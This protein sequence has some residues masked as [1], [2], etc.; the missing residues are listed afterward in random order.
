MP[1]Y[2]VNGEEST[3]LA[4]DGKVSVAYENGD[5]FEGSYDVSKKKSGSGVYTWSAGEDAPEDAPRQR[6]SGE[7]A[8]G[9]RNGFGTMEYTSGDSY[10][11]SWASNKRN[12]EGVYYYANGDIYSGTWESDAKN[13]PGTMNFA[14]GSQLVGEWYNGEISQGQWTWADGTVYR[15]GFVNGKPAGQG[16][17]SFPSG[18]TQGGKFSGGNWSGGSIGGPRSFSESLTVD[19][20]LAI[21]GNENTMVVEDVDVNSTFAE[22]RARIRLM[23]T[24]SSWPSWSAIKWDAGPSDDSTIA[25]HGLHKPDENGS[26][27]LVLKQGD[28]AAPFVKDS[29][30][31]E[32]GVG[33]V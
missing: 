30:V 31:S 21:E 15:G 2:T 29:R 5:T 7:Y 20:S 24:P 16:G 14:D 23:D 12:G 33:A 28:D 27:S 13:G 18:A 19:I 32:D 22:L 11:G 1:T 8:S 25:S 4:T 9:E 3:F 10:E 26:H 17:F 6:Y